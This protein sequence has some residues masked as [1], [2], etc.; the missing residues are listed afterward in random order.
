[1]ERRRGAAQPWPRART[2]LLSALILCW[3]AS[4]SSG[5]RAWVPS[6]QVLGPGAARSSLLLRG[7]FDPLAAV[8]AS[9]PVR[10]ATVDL[11]APKLEPFD[12]NLFEGD[13]RRLFQVIPPHL[14]PLPPLGRGPSGSG[15]K[16]GRR[17]SK[18]GMRCWAWVNVVRGWVHEGCTGASGGETGWKV[19]ALRYKW[20]EAG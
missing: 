2:L 12:A 14:Q 16:W 7:G 17:G 15:W 13:I 1:M 10:Q 11:D 5:S 8:S 6:A 18:W 3:H 19:V 9:P 4:A 20:L